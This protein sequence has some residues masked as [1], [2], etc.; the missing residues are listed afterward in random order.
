M[1]YVKIQF[2]ILHSLF[3]SKCTFYFLYVVQSIGTSS[4]DS[5]HPFIVVYKITML[6]RIKGGREL[7]RTTVTVE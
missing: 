3:M 6:F 7:K 5:F 2:S 1:Q 4:F